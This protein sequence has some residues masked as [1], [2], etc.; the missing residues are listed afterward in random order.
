[1][2]ELSSFQ[3]ELIETFHPD[4][5]VLLNITPDHL[6]RHKTMEA[7]AAAKARIFEKQTESDFAV[8][9]ADDPAARRLA[10]LAFAGWMAAGLVWSESA[11]S[12]FDEVARLVNYIGIVVLAWSYLDLDNWRWAAAGL[13]IA[14]IVVCGLADAARLFPSDFPSAGPDRLFGGSRLTY[15]LG[16]W[17]AMGAWA[18]MSLALVAGWAA[19]HRDRLIRSV[20]LAAAPLALLAVYLTYSRGAVGGVVIGTVAVIGLSRP[21][22]SA[23]IQLA[24]AWLAAAAVAL[25][26]RSQPSIANASGGDGGTLVA[27]ALAA[28]VA[29]CAVVGWRTDRGFTAMDQGS[30]RLGR[31]LFAFVAVGVVA[32]AFVAASGPTGTV[33][34]AGGPPAAPPGNAAGRLTALG[35]ARSEIWSSAW[36]AFESEPV[37]GIGSGAF[38]LWWQRDTTDK[39][40]I[41]DAHSLYLE[42]LAEDGVVGALALLVA[43]AALMGPA[44]AAL[45]RT[46]RRSQLAASVGLVAAFCVFLVQAGVDWMWE[47]TAVSVFALMGISIAGAAATRRSTGTVSLSARRIGAILLAAGGLA[48]NVPG[49]VAADRQQKAG[50]A[51]ALGV[52][53][54]A[55]EL[56]DQAVTAEPWSAAVYASRSAIELTTNQLGSARQDVQRAI[57]KEPDN[58]VFQ[59]LLAR[60]ELARGNPRAAIAALHEAQR[61][62]PAFSAGFQRT[63]QGI[64]ST[65][66]GPGGGTG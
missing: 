56:A 3:L 58:W 61:L 44:V 17:N 21:R 54:Q 7:Y 31:I 29:V 55:Q 65:E 48:V 47:S 25:A 38:D 11:G 43:L 32:A 51:L 27:L 50:Y 37:H 1:V 12:T 14:G 15:P 42:T 23:V 19:H 2:A 66:G 26:A 18:A 49:L 35:G 16:Y 10:L 24:T 4:I 60:V 28:A 41:R 53:G 59:A 22:R 52:D 36:R 8:V 62:R 63:I 6:D 33:T 34:Q 45:R 13:T 64:R 5:S 30:P 20:A 9:N 39:S 57:S 40:F 46:R